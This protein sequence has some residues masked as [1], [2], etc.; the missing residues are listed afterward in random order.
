MKNSIH[1]FLGQAG[2]FLDALASAIVDPGGR[3]AEREKALAAL[4]QV[5]KDP[6]PLI[7]ILRATPTG[8]IRRMTQCACKGLVDYDDLR[9]FVSDMPEIAIPALEAMST[10]P[11]KK[12]FAAVRLRSLDAP[13]YMAKIVA[14]SEQQKTRP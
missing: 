10:V 11:L 12:A 13:T 8:N 4:K 5:V 3:R 7:A 14:V 6:E 2:T 1:Q 9:G